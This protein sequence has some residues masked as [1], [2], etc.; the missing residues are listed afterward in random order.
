MDE[1]TRVVIDAIALEA[2]AIAH[3]KGWYDP[4]RTFGEHVLMAIVELGEMIQAYRDPTHS[5]VKIYTVLE[6]GKPEG[7]AVEMADC[8]I[9]LL[10][11]AVEYRLPLYDA[12]YQKMRYNATRPH[13]HGGKIL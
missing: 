7:V 6:D 4:P 10:D 11:T 13:R 1:V 5:P 3:E 2:N 12:L 9:R 8:I